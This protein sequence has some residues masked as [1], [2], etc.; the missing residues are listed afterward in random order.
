[1]DVKA[2]E[3]LKLNIVTLIRGQ[4][5]ICYDIFLEGCKGTI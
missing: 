2:T 5:F 4:L 1:M 3:N